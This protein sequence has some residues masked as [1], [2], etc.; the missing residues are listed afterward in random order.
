MYFLL[1]IK[2]LKRKDVKRNKKKDKYEENMKKKNTSYH[3]RSISK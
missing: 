3:T 1:R 2:T